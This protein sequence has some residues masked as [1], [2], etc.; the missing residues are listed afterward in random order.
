MYK[1]IFVNMDLL[2]NVDINNTIELPNSCVFNLNIVNDL[3]KIKNVEKSFAEETIENEKKKR[4]TFFNIESIII[5]PNKETLDI[6]SMWY[7]RY[8]FN[9]FRNM[10]N[11]EITKLVCCR[12][13][14]NRTEAYKK[15]C[16][17]NFEE[18]ETV[19]KRRENIPSEIIGFLVGEDY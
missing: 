17:P 14:E 16:D 8:E 11:R 19:L 18:K 12:I 2:L 4:V 7:S 5:I 15:L 3:E 10:F 13:A 9:H 1:N 6:L